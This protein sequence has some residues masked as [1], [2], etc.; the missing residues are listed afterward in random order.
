[1]VNPGVTAAVCKRVGS[2]NTPI[3]VTA[4]IYC[5]CNLDGEDDVLM[6]DVMLLMLMPMVASD[7]REMWG[8]DVMIAD[9]RV[10]TLCPLI[11]QRLSLCD[12]PS[13]STP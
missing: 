3:V 11:H 10:R 8:P 13:N 5:I 6:S 7:G 9:V 2:A 4:V 12:T 1:M